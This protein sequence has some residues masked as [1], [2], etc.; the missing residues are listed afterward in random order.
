[1]PHVQLHVSQQKQHFLLQKERKMHFMVLLQQPKQQHELQMQPVEQKN[2]RDVHNAR[3]MRCT[4]KLPQ[5]HC[6][7]FELQVKQRRSS[8]ITAGGRQQQQKLQQHRKQQISI[9]GST[10]TSWTQRPF[11]WQLQEGLAIS[12]VPVAEATAAAP[13]DAGAVDTVAATAA[14]APLANA[15]GG[16]TGLR[17]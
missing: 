7:L 10:S 2:L 8:C 14:G 13:A 4:I 17:H 15:T 12:S 16:L 6:V 5:W 11:R 3:H 9:E 1:M